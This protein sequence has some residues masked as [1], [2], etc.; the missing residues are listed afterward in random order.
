[1]AR[2]VLVLRTLSA[3]WNF[4]ARSVAAAGGL[5]AAL[6]AAVRSAAVVEIRLA[7]V[8]VHLVAVVPAADVAVAVEIHSAA[9]VAEIVV[10]V[11]EAV[12]VEDD[13]PLVA[14]T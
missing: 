6:A 2:L 1:M 3:D 9:A 12:T 5:P 10:G 11:A 4:S 13:S 7:A 14:Q 8:E